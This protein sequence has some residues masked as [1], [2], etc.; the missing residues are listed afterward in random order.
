MP[1]G[2]AQPRLAA[3]VKKQVIEEIEELLKRGVRKMTAVQ[4]VADDKASYP[5][6][7]DGT[8][9]FNGRTAATG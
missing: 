6:R 8:R 3:R 5:D 7:F 2:V 1:E 4:T 9:P